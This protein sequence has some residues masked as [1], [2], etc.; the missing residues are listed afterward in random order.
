MYDWH[1]KC[2]WCHNSTNL[3]FMTMMTPCQDIRSCVMLFYMPTIRHASVGHVIKSV[4]NRPF[5]YNKENVFI[6]LCFS[7][8]N[9]FFYIVNCCYQYSSSNMNDIAF[10][11]NKMHFISGMETAS[12]VFRCLT[13]NVFRN[14]NSQYGS[15]I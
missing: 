1:A 4:N 14:T 15:Y 7:S 2:F 12:F 5:W 9:K 13:K 6:P 11:K 3:V 10:H 8:H